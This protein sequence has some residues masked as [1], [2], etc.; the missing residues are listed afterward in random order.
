MGWF[1][2]GGWDEQKS[3]Q[4][5]FLKVQKIKTEFYAFQWNTVHTVRHNNSMPFARCQVL[6]YLYKGKGWEVL[7]K[8][9]HR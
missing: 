6:H 1:R 8:Q 2:K 7:K 5:V 9:A 4:D 3:E